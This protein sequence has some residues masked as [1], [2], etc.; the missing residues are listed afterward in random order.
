[1]RCT[2]INV[3]E[4]TGLG[5]YHRVRGIGESETLCVSYGNA[6]PLTI[7]RIGQ[8]NNNPGEFT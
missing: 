2:I 4:I 5:A 7:H 6:L 1:L 3:L 8:L